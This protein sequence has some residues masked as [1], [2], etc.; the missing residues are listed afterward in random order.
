M[1]YILILMFFLFWSCNAQNKKQS[2]KK[3]KTT[4]VNTHTEMTTEK[5]DIA[6]FEKN[7][8]DNEYNFIMENGTK[9]RQTESENEYSVYITPPPPEL[10]ETYKQYYKSGE[11]QRYIISYPKDFLKLKKEY[12]KSG[13]LIEEINYDPPYKFS[14]EQLLVLIEKEEDTID[15]YDKNT[16]IGRG[17][18]ENGTDWYITYKKVPMRREVIKVD[19]ITGEVLE[20]GFHPHEDN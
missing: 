5:F 14:F 3:N 17:S 20:R 15:L 10:F 13:K 7:K 18:D 19:G 11:L 1:K 6:T 8:I 2:T 16:S 9:V 4:T 12:D